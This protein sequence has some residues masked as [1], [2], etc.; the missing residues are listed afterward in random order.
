M[1]LLVVPVDWVTG[2]VNPVLQCLEF[3]LTK[4]L[5]PP[6]RFS[7]DLS[8]AVWVSLTASEE[9]SAVDIIDVTAFESVVHDVVVHLDSL[10]DVG[11]SEE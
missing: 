4:D 1:Q 2:K 5:S 10:D 9:G 11:L 3:V 7:E 8:V 6:P